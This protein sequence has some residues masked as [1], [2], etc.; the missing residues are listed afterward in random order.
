VEEKLSGRSLTPDV[1]DSGLFLLVEVSWNLG[2]FRVY[3][4][5]SFAPDPSGAIFACSCFNS[6]R[7]VPIPA[8]PAASV[9][10]VAAFL[11]TRATFDAV[12]ELERV[13]ALD[14]VL[15][16]P[17]RVLLALA[18]RAVLAV[19]RFVFLVTRLVAF[20]R[21]CFPRAVARLMRLAI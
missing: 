6:P 17:A 12:L 4:C 8:K 20:P 5:S 3:F 18:A 11:V 16:F 15:A 10:A 14:A 13:F 21:F 19:R 9:A 1:D 7:A 2:G